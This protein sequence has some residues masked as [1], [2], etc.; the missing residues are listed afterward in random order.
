MKKILLS[1][2]L[3]VA[4]VAVGQNPAPPAQGQP[5]TPP[6]QG[7]AAPPAQDAALAPAS[8]GS[9]QL[10]VRPLRC[11]AARNPPWKRRLLRS[12]IV[13]EKPRLFPAM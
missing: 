13:E 2:V 1:A 6:A 10:S 12:L 5:A 3:G 9:S 8:R 11:V 4:V 7:Q